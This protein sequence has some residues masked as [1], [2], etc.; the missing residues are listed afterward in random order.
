MKKQVN[1]K[2]PSSSQSWY[3]GSADHPAC[4]CLGAT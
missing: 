3:S 1:R 4:T 2:C